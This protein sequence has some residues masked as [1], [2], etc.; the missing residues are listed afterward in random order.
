M[1][2]TYEWKLTGLKKQSKG[3]VTDAIVQTYWKVI[4]TDEDGDTGE[5]VGATPFP[6]TSV[7]P[8][9][10]ID[11]TQLTEEQV[12]GWIKDYVS[13]SNVVTNYWGHIYEQIE[14]SI[15][16]KKSPVVSIADYEFPWAS[17]SAASGSHI[18]F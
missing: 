17:G 8:D 7:N 6:I 12:I 15:D 10:F 16:E 13:G 14:K 1:A 5:F 9:N 18:P 3:D 2:Y 4:A 11:Y